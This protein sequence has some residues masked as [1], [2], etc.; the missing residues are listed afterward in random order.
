MNIEDELLHGSIDLH[1]HSWPEFSLKMRGRVD[2]IEW[3]R[4]AQAAGMRAYVMK[5]HIFPTTAQAYLVNQIV[6][7]IKVFGSITLNVNTGLSPFAVELAGELGAKIVWMPTWSSKN[8]LSKS[9]I[10]ITRMIQFLSTIDQL[11]PSPEA[12]VTVLDAEGNL[13]PVI[14]EIMEIIKKYDMVL[15]TGHLSIEES[16]ALAKAAERAGVKFVL[17]HALNR[18]VNASIE[19]QKEIV[20][21]GG[22]IEHCYIT[23]MPMHGSLKLSAIAEAIKEVGP[24]HVVITTDAIC[25]WNAP[26]PEL[27]RMFIGSLLALGISEEDIKKMAHEN[28]AKLLGL[29]PEEDENE[30]RQ[31][32]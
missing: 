11:L 30:S 4:L 25:A 31:N 23:T 13:I 24:E 29:P 27:M 7:G 3:A 19:Q 2:D 12:G 20:K 26:P 21:M 5:S 32:A 9:G 28:P 22:Y 16:L 6:P 1:A 17:T 8:G 10:F 14:S 15:A 18:V